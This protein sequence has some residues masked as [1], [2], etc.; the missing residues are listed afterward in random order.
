MSEI[1]VQDDN[2]I[3]V[4]TMTDEEVVLHWAKQSKILIDSVE[5]LFKDGFTCHRTN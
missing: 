4:R 2:I 3:E 5:K 1:E